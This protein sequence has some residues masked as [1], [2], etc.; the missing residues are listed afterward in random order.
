MLMHII[1]LPG[2][3]IKQTN[4]YTLNCFVVVTGGTISEPQNLLKEQN[5]NIR[6]LWMLWFSIEK[7]HC[8][9]REL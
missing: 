9:T 2:P 7:I 3:E 5:P 4:C 8:Q 6:I 1:S